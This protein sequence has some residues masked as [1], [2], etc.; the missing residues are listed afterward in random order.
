MRL[1]NI[2]GS[3]F[4]GVTSPSDFDGAGGHHGSDCS[5]GETVSDTGNSGDGIGSRMTLSGALSLSLMIT[6]HWE[7]NR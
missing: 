1:P 3:G 2:Y 7:R 6:K 4:G 5:S